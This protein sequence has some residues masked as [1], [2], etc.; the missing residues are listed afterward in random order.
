MKK[1]I[2]LLFVLAIFS[3]ANAEKSDGPV[4]VGFIVYMDFQSNKTDG[5]NLSNS[6]FNAVVILENQILPYGSQIKLLLNDK[7][8]WVS[9]PLKKS[10]EFKYQ[11]PAGYYKVEI[12]K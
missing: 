1:A 9:K 4:Q 5:T 2:I 12:I 6:D 10:K 7:T 11:G 3:G 8:V